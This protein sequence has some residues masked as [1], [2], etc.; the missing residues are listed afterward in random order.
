MKKF[1]HTNKKYVFFCLYSILALF[2]ILLGVMQVKPPR[3][4]EAS[5]YYPA[6]IRMMDNI[7]R[8]T[9]EPHPSG[10]IEIER[11]RTEILAKIEAMGLS[12][13]VEDAAYSVDEYVED[14]RPERYTEEEWKQALEQQWE[15][16]EGNQIKLEYGVNSMDEWWEY[17]LHDIGADAL[18]N[19]LVKLDAPDS[20]R[21][22]MFVSHYDSYRD[23]PGAADDMMSVCAMLEAMRVHAQNNT[24]KNDLYFLL[25]DGEERNLMGAKK[26]VNAHPDLKDKLDM[27]INIDKRGSSGGVILFETSEQAYRLLNTV[28][29]SGAKPIGMSWLSDIYRMMPNTNTDFTPFLDAG[30]SG[31]NFGGVEG[32]QHYHNPGDSFDNLNPNTA[33]HFLLTTLALAEHMAN[34][35]LDELNKSS[36]DAVY[37]PFLPQVLVHMPLWVSNVICV[38]A[39]LLTLAYGLWQTK[40]KQLKPSLATILMGALLVLSIGSA[41]WFPAGSY[42][43][44]IPLFAMTIIKFLR[45]WNIA[46]HT[47]IAL[48][49]I[50]VLLIWVPVVFL[51]YV[52]V[53]Q[54][55]ML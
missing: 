2:G 26:F 29:Q 23:S 7:K 14:I 35:T 6:Y 39:C 16:D 8:F 22:I 44:Y 32:V 36:H 13:L 25:T 42:L 3:V 38:V 15:S 12:P 33:W 47:A 9:K 5:P 19:I 41:I 52:G 51:L 48:C 54:P 46:F 55:M 53:I 20:E 45:K 11:V 28:I 40:Q 24:L 17:R 27:V 37:F 18:Q 49:G 31:V 10:S 21:G 1:I 43:F 4:N 34:N 50:A 30:Y